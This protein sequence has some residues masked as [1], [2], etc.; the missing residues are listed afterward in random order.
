MCKVTFRLPKEA[1]PDASVVMVAGEF[2]NWDA[3]QVKMRKLKNGDFKATVELPC[4]KEF[5]FKYL[6]DSQRWENDW[7]ADKYAPNEYGGEDSV[8]VV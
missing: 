1:A 7:A 4:D 8:V 3:S 5:R 6:I 2:N